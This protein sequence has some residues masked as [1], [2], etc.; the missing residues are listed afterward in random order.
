MSTGAHEMP[1]D[2]V[3]RETLTVVPLNSERRPVT[4]CECSSRPAVVAVW[5]T[6]TGSGYRGRPVRR[7]CGIH[8]REE[9]AVGGP[10]WA[11]EYNP[12][13]GEAGTLEEVTSDW[14]DASG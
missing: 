3:P 5:P 7:L 2:V 4:W 10:F 12:V 1:N 11:G 14:L 9:S 6:W 8:Y 13:T